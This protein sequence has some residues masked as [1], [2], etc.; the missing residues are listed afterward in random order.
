MGSPGSTIGGSELSLFCS[1][2]GRL[3]GDPSGGGRLSM[4]TLGV[5]GSIRVVEMSSITP[6]PHAT[7]KLALAALIQRVTENRIRYI[8]RIG[9]VGSLLDLGLERRD[10]NRTN[11]GNLL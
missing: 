9:I 11:I 6:S 7:K 10:A 5:A 3:R 8:R 1:G 4:S 2:F